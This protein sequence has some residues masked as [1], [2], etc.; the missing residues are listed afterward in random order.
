MKRDEIPKVIASHR[1][2]LNSFGVKSLAIFGSIA[3][4]EARSG[5]DVDI[6]VEFQGK[7][8]FNQYMK[9]KFFLQDMLGR[10][11]DLVTAKALKP[12]LRPY[13]E[14]EALYVT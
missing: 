14:K 8:T 13:I 1:M 7:P 11:V 12:R 2:E 6:L 10:P 3:R 4:N 9:L 5:S